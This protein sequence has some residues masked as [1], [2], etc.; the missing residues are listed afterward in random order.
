MELTIELA[1]T[2]EGRRLQDGFAKLANVKTNTD[3]T[4]CIGGSVPVQYVK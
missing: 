2:E 3:E 1:I 4:Y